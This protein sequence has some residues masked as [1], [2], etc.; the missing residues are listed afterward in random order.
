M[1]ESCCPRPE[2][3][4]QQQTVKTRTSRKLISGLNFLS[5]RYLEIYLSIL[6][7]CLFKYTNLTLD[8]SRFILICFTDAVVCLHCNPKRKQL[9]LQ[10]LK[11]PLEADSESESILTGAHIKMSNFTAGKTCL[12]P[13][14]RNCFC[15]P[16]LVLCKY[17]GL[18]G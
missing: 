14:V 2:I 4:L 9:K 12:Q 8:E 18:L 11:W 10:F 6:L 13:G 16:W 1:N 7:S 17:F 3:M 15:S 5:K